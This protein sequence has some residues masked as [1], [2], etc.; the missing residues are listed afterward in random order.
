MP[1]VGVKLGHQQGLGRVT[2][3]CVELRL[4]FP[5]LSAVLSFWQ[6]FSEWLK[7]C[8]VNYKGGAGMHY[9][10]QLMTKVR[11]DWT[12]RTG[13]TAWP[14]TSWNFLGGGPANVPS[15]WR[16]ARRKMGVSMPENPLPVHQHGSFTPKTAEDYFQLFLLWQ[17][18]LHRKPLHCGGKGCGKGCGKFV[19]RWRG[20]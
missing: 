7:R 14:T 3:F 16:C 17:D 4:F 18:H 1:V 10:Y 11:T 8:L 6:E 9:H 12:S 20:V 19:F 5:N 2:L 13:L 15:L